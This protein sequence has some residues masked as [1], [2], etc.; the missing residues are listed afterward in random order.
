MNVLLELALRTKPSS[1][2][3]LTVLFKKVLLLLTLRKMFAR[4]LLITVLFVNMLELE[5]W[6][7]IPKV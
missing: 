4:E 3:V 6:E 2:L 5:K 7:K 1:A